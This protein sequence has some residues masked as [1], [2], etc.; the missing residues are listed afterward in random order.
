[1]TAPTTGA[2]DA[3]T[4]AQAAQD[5]AVG[6]GARAFRVWRGADGYGAFQ[7]YVAEVDEGMVPRRH[8]ADPG[9]PRQRSRRP[10]E[11][12]G[13]EVWVMLG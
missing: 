5:D 7:D 2:V 8:P 9:Q 12:Q 11:L 3:Y 13:G 6:H 10:M 1:M 4:A